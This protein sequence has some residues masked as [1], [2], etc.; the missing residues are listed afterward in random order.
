M[1]NTLVASL[2]RDLEELVELLDGFDSEFESVVENTNALDDLTDDEVTLLG[3]LS[4]L[5]VDE[6]L[7]YMTSI[8]FNG[9]GIEKETLQSIF[10][11]LDL[12]KRTMDGQAITTP[13]V[14]QYDEWHNL[15]ALVNEARNY[16][17]NMIS[18]FGERPRG[19]DDFRQESNFTVSKKFISRVSKNFISTE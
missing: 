19:Q 4:G 9:Y 17:Q 15:V 5:V 13:T 18:Q 16:T 11:N 6:I 12:L 7:E 14:T 1:A 8:R 2:L 10:S 3:N